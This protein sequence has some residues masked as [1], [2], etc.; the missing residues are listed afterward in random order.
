MT[1][2]IT[3][4]SAQIAS[5]RTVWTV[6][7]YDT[8]NDVIQGRRGITNADSAAALAESS[9]CA[10]ERGLGTLYVTHTPAG[11]WDDDPAEWFREELMGGE[12]K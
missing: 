10:W 4:R 2:P 3:L 8:D 1:E 12:Q 9:E 7:A 11:Y 5:S 6:I